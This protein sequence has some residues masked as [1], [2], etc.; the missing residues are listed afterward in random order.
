[1]MVK[2]CR[3]IKN[4]IK[5]EANRER[6]AIKLTEKNI[7]SKF[8]VKPST[9]IKFKNVTDSLYENYGQKEVPEKALDQVIQREFGGKDV[10]KYRMIFKIHAM[11]ASNPLLLESYKD[12]FSFTGSAIEGLGKNKDNVDLNDNLYL[13]VM[14]LPTISKLYKDV[15]ET[16]NPKGDEKFNGATGNVRI[17]LSLPRKMRKLDPTGAVFSAVRAIESFVS[18]TQQ[19]IS[20]F[21]GGEGRLGMKDVI[22]KIKLLN[23]EWVTS[24]VNQQKALKYFH[25]VFNG[26]MV[27]KD[28]K[29]YIHATRRKVEDQ[30]ADY[31]A[32]YYYY[33]KKVGYW[34]YKSTKDPVYDYQDLMLFDDYI[35]G[36]GLSKKDK[37][38]F[39]NNIDLQD[40]IRYRIET[41]NMA[42]DFTPDMIK[43]LEESVVTARKIH[44]K[45]FEDIKKRFV[46]LEKYLVK[47]LKIWLPAMTDI[48]LR[49]IMI[50][51]FIN[52]DFSKIPA[53]YKAKAKF[54]Y[55]NFGKSTVLNPFF[56]GAIHLNEKKDSS[57]VSYHEDI[58]PIKFDR[59][60]E[61][62]NIELDSINEELKTV[63]GKERVALYNRMEEI[64]VQ[65][66]RIEM[67]LNRMDEFFEDP[68]FGKRIYTSKDAKN[69]R[70]ISNAIDI[71]DMRDDEA[72]YHDYLKNM[73]STLERGMLGLRVIGAVRQAKSNKLIINYIMGLFNTVLH[74]PDAR[75]SVFGID[76]SLSRLYHGVFEKLPINISEHKL[77]RYARTI[78]AAITARYLGRIS[79]AVLN[80]TAT[81]IKAIHYGWHRYGR[82]NE[83]IKA[84]KKQVDGLVQESGILE[85]GDFF[86]QSLVKD[87]SNQ[88]NITRDEALDITKHMLVYH[89]NRKIGLSKKEAVAIF[90]K[91]VGGIVKTIPDVK[92]L[93]SRLKSLKGKKIKAIVDRWANWAITKNYSAFPIQ[94]IEMGNLKKLIR[95]TGGTFEKF[96]EALYEGFLSELTMSA[97]EKDLRT[98]SFVIGI[99]L[100]QESGIIDKDFFKLLVKKDLTQE[101][102]ERLTKNKELATKWGRETTRVL[103]FGLST[104]DVGEL[105]RIGG[106]VMTK[107]TI[108]S[109]QKYGYDVNLFKDYY[110]SLTGDQKKSAYGKSVLEIIKSLGTLRSKKAAE[111]LWEKN[112]HL[113]RVRN[114]IIMMGPLTLLMDFVIFGPFLGQ[115]LKRIPFLRG[116][117]ATKI[118]S[119]MSSDLVSLTV[120]L[121]LWLLVMA[122]GDEDEEEMNDGLYYKLRRIPFLGFGFGWG[123]DIMWWL[124]GI[125]TDVNDRELAKRTGKA[126]GPLYPVPPPV[127]SQTEQLINET[128]TYPLIKN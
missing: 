113:A 51:A 109:Q 108:W 82:A 111:K 77:D 68:V 40:E 20:R 102:K 86:S 105:A 45:V 22:E 31:N 60:L 97:T 103:D 53:D 13:D 95:K 63:K 9:K 10:A 44:A 112:P 117:T 5:G 124:L 39:D 98:H 3:A 30:T 33:D 57:P 88:E 37:E 59:I 2:A 115:I 23:P 79:T 52:G 28:G 42:L 38:Q 35:A 19:H 99:L 74:K 104:T 126:I 17:T 96:N 116:M 16:T 75:A 91:S 94:E 49:S 67:T 27:I 47:E 14:T 21:M 107:F 15:A 83:V 128:I 25:R 119:G 34:K 18:N 87:L 89:A 125:A 61:D 85:F 46:L 62:I 93:E 106:G 54:L 120:S 48:D 81:V 36:K 26:W 84:Y 69:L 6:A 92:R 118:M 65:R 114:F 101:E 56:A 121:P 66:D 73:Y 29:L 110:R 78:S 71:R 70:H 123:I 4:T 122:M 12:E 11:L 41:R 76:M 80:K 8:P 24:R 58:L 64:T 55:N 7:N 50:E 72:V 43:E 1:M 100:A 32:E 90:R 127:A